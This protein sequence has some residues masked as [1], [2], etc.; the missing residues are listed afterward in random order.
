M[1]KEGLYYPDG[2]F[3]SRSEI[4]R[5]L[6]AD[7]LTVP[8]WLTP[9]PPQRDFTEWQPIIAR[10]QE[11]YK[12]L[13]QIPEAV[14]VEIATDTPVLL[15]PI[16]DIHALHPEC[17]LT[18][19]GQ[20]VDLVK[21]VNGYFL[22][23]GDLTDSIFWKQSP[24]LA[25]EQEAVLYMRSALAYMAEDNHLLCGW[26]GDHD[27]WALDK[28]GSHTLYADFW[29]KL[30]AHLLDGVS[31][32]DVGLFNKD[33]VQNYAI[34]GSHRHKGFSIYSDSHSAWRQYNDEAKTGRNVISITAHKHTK[35]YN[36][37]TRKTFGGREAVIHSLSLG[38][39]KETDRYSRKHGWPRKGDETT[40]SFGII[41]FPNEDRT[42]VFWNLE[43]AVD[44][45]ARY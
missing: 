17:N 24:Q 1:S 23:F 6:L 45:L 38:T 4:R 33:G 28:H 15:C 27:A 44:F 22:T 34:I 35:G 7:E 11:E 42:E 21:S 32:V 9:S 41:V 19:F 2:S 8:S 36:R 13:C 39:Y 3:K 14:H 30:N 16:G 26:L 18:R 10:R 31:Y 29:E 20:D 43:H 5:K 12:E 37:Q 40:G 25:S